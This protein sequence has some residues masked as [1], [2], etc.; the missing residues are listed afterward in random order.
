MKREYKKTALEKKWDL[1]DT[2]EM[3]NYKKYYKYV[4]NL[5]G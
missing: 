3:F 4:E 5:K 2:K 1:G